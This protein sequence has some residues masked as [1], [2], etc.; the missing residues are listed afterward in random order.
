[1]AYNLFTDL[2]KNHSVGGSSLY[3]Y[4][5][6][7]NNVEFEIGTLCKLSSANDIGSFMAITKSQYGERRNKQ[8]LK[9]NFISSRDFNDDYFSLLSVSY[10]YEGCLFIIRKPVVNLDSEGKPANTVT[11]CYSVYDKK[12]VDYLS[13]HLHDD[14]KYKEGKMYLPVYYEKLGIIHDFASK[15]TIDV[16]PESNENIIELCKREYEEYKE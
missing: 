5:V 3:G 9:F 2:Q 8:N 12:Y 16:G 6:L 7:M 10:M 13:S 11:F 1:M 15:T 14:D 4:L